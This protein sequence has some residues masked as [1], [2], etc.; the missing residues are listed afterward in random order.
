MAAPT[1]RADSPDGAGAELRRGCARLGLVADARRQAMLLH[2]LELLAKWNSAFNL[3]AVRDV[4][5]MVCRHLLDSLAVAPHLSGGRLLDVG[6]GAGLPGVPLAIQYPDREFH[7]LD[8]NGK[9]TRFLFQVKTALC[10]DNMSIH[11]A[12][13]ETFDDDSGFDAVLSRAF[14]PLPDMVRRCR[15][16]TA[17]GGVLLAMKGALAEAE[18]R[19]VEQMPGLSVQVIALDVPGLSEARHLVAIR[20][21]E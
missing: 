19:A 16:L 2:Y 9:K 3:T 21:S 5:A 4:P 14:A 10:L 6:S 1:V 15:H 20:H 12:R 13:A 8:S 11:R 7:L 18:I 17:A